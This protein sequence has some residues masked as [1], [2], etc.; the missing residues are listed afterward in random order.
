MVIVDY[1]KNQTS[2]FSFKLVDIYSIFS[3]NQEPQSA[4]VCAQT[5]IIFFNYI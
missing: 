3:Q 4:D 5:L 1:T 2:H